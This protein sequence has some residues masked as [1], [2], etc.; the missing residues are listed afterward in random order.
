MVGVVLAAGQSRRMDRPKALLRLGG[1]TFLER[2]VSAL[3]NGGCDAVLVVV[4][5]TGA[6]VPEQI[7]AAAAA[8]GARVVHNPAVESEQIDSLRIALRALPPATAAVLTTPVDVPRIDSGT[9]AALIA[10]FRARGAPI[11]RPVC[12]TRH[13]HPVL[14]A[15]RLF[16]ELLAEP[17]P[18]GARGVV[19]AHAAE[20][21][22]VTVPDPAVLL[23][24]D[25]PADYRRLLHGAE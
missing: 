8:V 14:F 2:V 9:V 21:E 3:Q 15:R 25:T 18:H 4:G 19:H 17:L 5:P 11:V 10:A 16:P 23:D 6:A 1:R 20:I 24:V 13:G 22:D 7:A 12:G